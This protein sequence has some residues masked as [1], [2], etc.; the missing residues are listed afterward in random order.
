MKPTKDIMNIHRVEYEW[1]EFFPKGVCFMS[2]HFTLMLWLL[3]LVLKLSF[4]CSQAQLWGSCVTVD[5]SNFGMFSVH[6]FVFVLCHSCTMY[7]R[8]FV[9]S[10]IQ[11]LVLFNLNA[12][13]FH[14]YSN[15]VCYIFD[16]IWW[17][18][19]SLWSIGRGDILLV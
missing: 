5:A 14:G 8:I 2:D 16:Y 12:G 11:P 17:F 1:H 18:H 13:L 4:P 3:L 15:L 7:W 10:W 9:L 6:F 19:W